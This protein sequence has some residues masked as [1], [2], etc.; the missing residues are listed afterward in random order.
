LET[1]EALNRAGASLEW[2]EGVEHDEV[3]REF[4]L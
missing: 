4:G 3:L 1:M 2:G